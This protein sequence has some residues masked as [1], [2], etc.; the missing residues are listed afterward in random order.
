MK[1]SGGAAAYV[2][3]DAI[4]HNY[5]KIRE[6]TPSGA[7]IMCV[8]KADAYGHGAERLAPLYESLGAGAFGAATVSEAVKIRMTGTKLP[9][10]I[11]GYTPIVCVSELVEYD[12]TQSV[13]SAEYARA[14]SEAAV[15]LGKTVKIHVKIDTG[16]SR[17]G[18]VARTEA[19]V[20]KIR[21]AVTLPG[22]EP[23]GIFTHLSSADID[24][25]EFTLSQLENFSFV[26]ECLEQKLGK[27]L[28]RHA[29]NSAAIID[30][31]EFAF[32]MVRAGIILYGM[33]PS[34]MLIGR[35]GLLPAMK[36]RSEVS[37][38]KVVEGGTSVGYSRRFIAEKPTKIATVQIGYA[39]GFFRYGSRGVATLTVC[40]KSAKTVGNVCMDQLMLDVSDVEGVGMGDEVIIFG[41]GGRSAEALASELGTICYELTTAVGAR[42]P[43]VYTENGKIVDIKN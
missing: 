22:L 43:R 16:M 28:V 29:A 17:I 14:L 34:D 36:L 1:F 15:S 32:D 19:D 3:L 12:I 25:R 18:F 2:S 4:R 6:A 40:G 23:V 9:I 21:D 10:L 31:P 5:L 24:E 42:V 11:L 7:K 38:V 20:L 26:S 8:I 33:A 39:D 35:L 30:Y 13:F 27:R 41:E 37:L